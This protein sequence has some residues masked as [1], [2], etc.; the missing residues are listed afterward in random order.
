[1][2]NGIVTFPARRLSSETTIVPI[3]VRFCWEEEVDVLYEFRTRVK[4]RDW[5][6]WTE[7]GPEW[8][9]WRPMLEFVVDLEGEDWV[10]EPWEG[11]MRGF[12]KGSDVGSEMGGNDDMGVEEDSVELESRMA[13]L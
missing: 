13:A 2:A 10:E 11:L 5:Y 8:R 9:L 1:M 4:S 6:F 7:L 12:D 3:I